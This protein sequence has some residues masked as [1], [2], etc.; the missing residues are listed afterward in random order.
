[1]GHH[2]LLISLAAV[3]EAPGLRMV[4][5]RRLR[6]LGAHYLQQSVCLLPARPPTT[7]G[8]DELLARL[9]AEGAQGRV[10]N[11]GLPDDEA[12]ELIAC[13]CAERSDEY[14]EV[15]SR[16]R[17]FFAEITRERERG[18]TTYTEVE[19]SAVDLKRLRQWLAAIEER[20]HFGA[21]GRD[22]AV[23]AVEE[24]ARLLAEFEAEAYARELS[25]SAD[26]FS[27]A[28]SGLLRALSGGAGAG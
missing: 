4:A 28:S 18:R 21:A 23:A 25:P 11:I 12:Q 13:F 27:R 8:V 2:F 19:E 16:T 20:D 5:W 17:E 22:E 10:F 1:M 3:G 14:R 26:P 6:A 7:T 24:C 9:R 15:V